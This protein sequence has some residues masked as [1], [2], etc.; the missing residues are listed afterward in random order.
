VYDLEVLRDSCKH[1]SAEAAILLVG[2]SQQNEIIECSIQS[3]GE[4]SLVEVQ[5][6]SPALKFIFCWKVEWWNI[7]EHD[8]VLENGY[9]VKYL[10]YFGHKSKEDDLMKCWMFREYTV[11]W[12]LSKVKCTSIAGTARQPLEIGSLLLYI[13][14][15]SAFRGSYRLEN[16]S[17]YIMYQDYHSNTS[18]HSGWVGV[19]GVVSIVVEWVWLV[20]WA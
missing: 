8:G 18:R 17:Q 19:V 12:L 9:L 5:S 7:G 4:E 14:T 1:H 2:P 13:M 6:L 3:T 11:V 15:W 20:W 10:R 16:I